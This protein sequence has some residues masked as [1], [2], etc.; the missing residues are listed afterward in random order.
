[1]CGGDVGV[2][3]FFVGI[4]DAAE[5]AVGAG[6]EAGVFLKLPIFQVMPGFPA[7]LGEVGNF[8]LQI[9]AFLQKISPVQEH[10]PLLF[11]TGQ[12]QLAAF[13]LLKKAGARL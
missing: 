7:R 10:M 9:A 2:Q 11:F 4:P 6:A 12:L 13:H 3:V 1:M 8:V 5:I